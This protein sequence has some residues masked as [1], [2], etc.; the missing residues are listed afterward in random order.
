MLLFKNQQ[1][2]PVM[3]CLL[4]PGMAVDSSS[5]LKVEAGTEGRIGGAASLP[6]ASY[7]EVSAYVKSVLLIACWT[8]P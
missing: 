4:V 6:R 8:Q 3:L 7:G 5:F 2:Y 1:V